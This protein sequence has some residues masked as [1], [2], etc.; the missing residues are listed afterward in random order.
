M[1]G[2]VA[3]LTD[4]QEALVRAVRFACIAT[5]RACLTGIVGLHLHCQRACKRGFVSNEAM[6]FSKGPP[7]GMLVRP[8]LLPRGLFAMPSFG[9]FANVC[10]VLKT[11]DAVWVALDNVL[12]DGMVRLQLQPS[13]SSTDDHKAS[14]SGPSAFA[15]QA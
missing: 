4:K 5:H 9:S 15:L 8:S 10:Q 11:D 3:T 13:L 14:G 2:I 6:Q 7:G 1:E 12:G